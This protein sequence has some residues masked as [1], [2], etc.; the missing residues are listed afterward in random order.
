MRNIVW[1][2]FVNVAQH[3]SSAVNHFGT[4]QAIRASMLLWNMNILSKSISTTTYLS[5]YLSYKAFIIQY[6]NKATAL[7]LAYT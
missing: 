3:K 1:N 2:Y 4:D 5:I 6:R 7:L